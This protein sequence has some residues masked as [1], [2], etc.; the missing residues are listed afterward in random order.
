MLLRDIALQEKKVKVLL[1]YA[2]LSSGPSATV[3][4]QMRPCHSNQCDF[5]AVAGGAEPAEGSI[6]AQSG[7]QLLLLFLSCF[8]ASTWMIF[9]DA[10]DE[11]MHPS[12]LRAAE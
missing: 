4:L 6:P 3:P 11:S 8:I 12:A 10:H 2:R 7:P 5:D 1:A 9:P